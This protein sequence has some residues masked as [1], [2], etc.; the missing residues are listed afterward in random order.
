MVLLTVTMLPIIVVFVSEKTSSFAGRS[1]AKKEVWVIDQNVRIAHGVYENPDRSLSQ[2]P[3]FIL[4]I[5]VCSVLGDSTVADQSLR[6]K[7]IIVPIV[8]SPTTFHRRSL[9]RCS[10]V[11]KA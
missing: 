2:S 5:C 11:G 1:H 9:L 3:P 10:R 8:I 6:P 7:A 4:A